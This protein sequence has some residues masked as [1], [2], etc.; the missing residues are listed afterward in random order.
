MAV[1]SPLADGQRSAAWRR[2][3]GVCALTLALVGMW[4]EQQLWRSPAD[5]WTVMALSMTTPG[6]LAVLFLRWE[7]FRASFG[8][9][10]R[11]VY[12]AIAVLAAL[13]EYSFHTQFL[14]GRVTED[15]VGTVVSWAAH[16]V[17][18][19]PI[20]EEWVYRG[21]LWEAC[22]RFLGAWPTIVVTSVLF[23]VHHGPDRVPDYPMLFV[24]G[25]IFGWLRHRTGSLQPC[26]VG[27][28]VYNALAWTGW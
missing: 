9:R 2:R 3:T 28:S 12:V 16:V 14:A 17:L 1:A 5:S 23:A 8:G 24:G 27:H 18:I 21:A 7:G 10:A 6:L 22:R 25:C 20:L 11:P 13:A 19:G 26:L 15:H 4:W